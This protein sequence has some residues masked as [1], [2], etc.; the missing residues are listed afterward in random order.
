MTNPALLNVLFGVQD[1][2]YRYLYT[3]GGSAIGVAVVFGLLGLCIAARA[4][5]GRVRTVGLPTLSPP[6]PESEAATLV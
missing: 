2:V 6:A 4:L 1:E 5:P 3:F